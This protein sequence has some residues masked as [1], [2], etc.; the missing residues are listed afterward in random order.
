MVV[1][2]VYMSMIEYSFSLYYIFV[3][4]DVRINIGFV[5]DRIFGIFLVLLNGVYVFIWIMILDYYVYV[6]LQIVV[7]IEVFI[8]LIIMMKQVIVIFLQE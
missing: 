7:N 2:C 6:Y 5:Y 3:F 8:G 4:D 1:F